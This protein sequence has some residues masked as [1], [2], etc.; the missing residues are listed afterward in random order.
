MD[1]CL[2]TTW[3][4]SRW[5]PVTSSFEHANELFGSF[6][7]VAEIFAA[8]HRGLCFTDLVSYI[9]PLI[10]LT[11]WPLYLRQKRP[12][13]PLARRRLIQSASL[14]LQGIRGGEEETKFD[15]PPQSN[16]KVCN[17]QRLLP[18]PY[19]PVPLTLSTIATSAFNLSKWRRVVKLP[20]VNKG[21]VDWLLHM[22]SILNFAYFQKQYL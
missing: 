3:L 1:T 22:G 20:V 14:L 2:N 9:W 15:Y 16:V 19:M 11:P 8:F 10:S 6:W 18:C 21:R 5:G 4:G 7:L 13:C 12:W 17:V